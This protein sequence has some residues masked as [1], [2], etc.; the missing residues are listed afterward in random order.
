MADTNKQYLDY[1]GLSKYNAKVK[2]ELDKKVNA[3]AG[4]GLSTNDYTTAEK[5]KLSG[6]TN[7]VLPAATESALGGIKVPVTSDPVPSDVGLK[8]DASGAAFVNWAAAPKATASDYG[9]MKLGNGLKLNDDT[10]AAEIDTSVVGGAT[11][12]WSDVTDKPD[13]ALKSDLSSVYTFKGSVANYAALPTTDLKIGDVYNT[14]DT[15][16]NYGWTGTAWDPLGS[17]FTVEAITEDQINALFT[18]GT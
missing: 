14:E 3:E 11:V 5:E 1:E 12:A 15:D 7:Y 4:K 16:M 18:T 10:G 8:A 13:L 2:A 6:L 9:V 17:T